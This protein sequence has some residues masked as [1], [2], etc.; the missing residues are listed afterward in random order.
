MA[1]GAR[2]G[3]AIL[4]RERGADAVHRRRG[5]L[6]GR[7][8]VRRR[9]AGGQG[10]R[11]RPNRAGLTAAARMTTWWAAGVALLMSLVV[12][13]VSAPCSI[14]MLTVD[15]SRAR[16]SRAFICRGRP[17][18]PLVGVWAFSSTGSSSARRARP[19]CAT[20]C[21]C[22]SRSFWSRGGRSGRIGNHGLWA[23]LYVHYA[24]R[25]GTLLYYFPALVRSAQS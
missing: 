8:R 24:A 4:G 12:C 18:A 16:D 7:P 21:S 9:S 6:S 3:D 19:R 25:T 14:D 2:Q 22:R 11:A 13:A 17:L 23:S 5:V 1:Q 20:R 10:G 15:Q